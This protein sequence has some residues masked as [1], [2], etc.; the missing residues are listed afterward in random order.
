MSTPILA[1]KLYIPP[2]R[3]TLVRRPRLLARLNAAL[4]HKVTLI[5][6]PAGYGKTTLVSSWIADPART[7]FGLP[8]LD[9]GVGSPENPSIQNQKSKIKNQIAWLSLDESD[10]DPVRFLTYLVAALQTLA[11]HWGVGVLALLQSPQP[12]PLA[13]TLT[14]LVN[15]IAA[16]PDQLVLILDDYHL[17]DA[18]PNGGG[19]LGAPLGTVDQALTFLIEHLPPPMHLVIT[20]REDPQLPLARLRARGEL[21][22]VRAADLRFTPAEAADFLN[23]MMGL[24]LAAE[25]ITALGVR[26]EGWIA[27]LQLAALSLRG[28][29]D[30]PGF[31]Q[32]FTGDHRYIGDYLVEEVLQRQPAH[33][34]TFLLQTAILDR[35]CGP[36]CDAVTQQT[37]GRGLLALLERANLFV[38]PLDDKREWYRYHHL[39]ADVLHAHALEEQPTQVAT[40][41]GRASAWY[42]AHGLRA[43]AIHHALAAADF[44][45]AADLVELTWPA[46]HRSN[47]RSAALLRWMKALPAAVVRTRPVL[48]VGYAWEYLNNGELEAAAAYLQ[49]AEQWLDQTDALPTDAMTFMDAE[50][51]R[52]L[53]EEIASARTFLSMAQGDIASTVTYAQRALDLL[54]A[55]AY[56]RRGP[57]VAL[58]GLAYWASGEL[59]AAYQALAEGMAGFQQAG[60]LI[61]AL[62]GTYGL[63]DI[64]T[65]Q[66]RLHEAVQVYKQALQ[67]AQAQGEP[68]IQGTADLYLGLGELA[69]EQGDLPAAA[70]YLAQ[71]EAL[72][73]GA[74]L[75]NWPCRRAIV[76]A[77]M[78]QTLGDLAGALDLLDEAA[79]HYFRGPVPDFRPIAAL[80][81]RVWVRQ[82]RLTE[83]L[84]WVRE[85]GLSIADELSYLREFEH[86][87]LARVLIARYQHDRSKAHLQAAITLLARL[88]PAAETGGRIGSVIEI[89][90]LQALAYEAQD[91]LPLALA[92]LTRALTLA[93]PAGC[94][95]LF[96]DEGTP[97]ARLLSAA[98][99]HGVMPDYSA[100]LLA[101]LGTAQP[102]NPHEA[103]R[104]AARQ[105][106]PLIEPLSERELEVLRLLGTELSGP[107]MAHQLMVSLNTLRTHTKNI[108]SKLGVNNRRAAVRR[109]EELGL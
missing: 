93:E 90:I 82:G 28:R 6:A 63:A 80:K 102:K 52:L 47:F 73:E 42:E 19:L 105:L 51:F 16:L 4:Q 97:M 20:T 69:R 46:L 38:V 56:V 9:F 8:I 106:H 5:S 25:Q 17:I 24:T 35:L 79:R 55:N 71:S 109:A 54:P 83:A 77:Q 1:T 68:V 45:R 76:Q 15:E 37:D 81:V 13:T 98:V 14:M 3:P 48:S 22:E 99:I 7:S 60:N 41:H 29:E 58:L 66:G 75:P 33:V 26:T 72:G 100:K 43:E 65:V 74:A 39:F 88:L 12:P 92:A 2:P 40:W 87:T 84:G 62:S 104:P 94:V 78:Q 44:A 31:I 10:N 70:Q 57:A 86:V 89:L 49:D 18:A 64:R 23:Q 36:L 85:R 103:L 27:G 50:E 67:L 30:I 96:V 95:R 21:N 101:A 59:E 32:A 61:F 108:F 34:R 107:E 91:N 11:P 53:P